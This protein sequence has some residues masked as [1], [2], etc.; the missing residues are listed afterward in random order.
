VYS[1]TYFLNKDKADCIFGIQQCMSA[2]AV[3]PE[4]LYIITNE[5]APARAYVMYI[6]WGFSSWVNKKL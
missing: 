4:K 5:A 3:L 1:K 6:I 2:K